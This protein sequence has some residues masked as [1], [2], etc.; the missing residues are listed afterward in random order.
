MGE[1]GMWSGKKIGVQNNVLDTRS[2]LQSFVF[3]KLFV[4]GLAATMTTTSVSLFE[5]S[6]FGE[7]F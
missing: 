7:V 5:L 3:R 2:N 6:V 1:A 4:A